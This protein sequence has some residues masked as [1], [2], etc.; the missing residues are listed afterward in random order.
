MTGRRR[1]K[2]SLWLQPPQ[3]VEDDGAFEKAPA[4]RAR[5]LILLLSVHRQE[6]LEV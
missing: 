4:S 3:E 5:K 1:E 2:Q 6:A